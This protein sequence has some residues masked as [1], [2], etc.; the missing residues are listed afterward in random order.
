[1]GK[2]HEKLYLRWKGEESKGAYLLLSQWS[3]LP[4]DMELRFIGDG[5]DFSNSNKNSVSLI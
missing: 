5:P 3:K 2:K 1:M 4:S